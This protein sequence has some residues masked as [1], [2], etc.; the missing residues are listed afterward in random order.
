MKW[1]INYRYTALDGAKYVMRDW[2]W[3]RPGD[4][5]AVVKKRFLREVLEPERFDVFSVEAT[6]E[7][8][9]GL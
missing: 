1:K 8:A 7:P 3:D 2:A 5:S 6:G 9:E 4:T